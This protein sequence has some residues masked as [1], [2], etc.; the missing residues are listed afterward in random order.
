MCI[1]DRITSAQDLRLDSAKHKFL[2]SAEELNP[3]TR[4]IDNRLAARIGED[5]T[6]KDYFS[7]NPAA[8]P[9][10]WRD[11]DVFI[12][13]ILD[14][15]LASDVYAAYMSQEDC[16]YAADCRFW[17]DVMRQIILPSDELSELLESNSIYWND[18][19]MVTGTFVLKSIKRAAAD[20]SA[21]APLQLLPK[22][23]DDE[24]AEF[25]ASLFRHVTE[26]RE[27]YRSYVDRFID[28][29]QWDTDRLAFM[30]I[31]IML[32]A[33]AELL[34]YPLIPVA[35]TLN[36]YIEIANDYSTAKSGQFIN[37]ILYSVIRSLHEEGKLEKTFESTDRN[38]VAAQ[39]KETK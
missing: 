19:L 13:Y 35:V 38:S 32:T 28:T 6:L 26:N 37:G 20:D 4:F 16:D 3:N 36:E 12:S 11:I 24:D 29:R 27:L 33:I 10:K 8:D 21:E 14:R 31:V 15:I 9:S 25:G 22:Y 5:E 7:A 34:N 18:D 17:R 39:E 23:M 2:P 30:D 1:R